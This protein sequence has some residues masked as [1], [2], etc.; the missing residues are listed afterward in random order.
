MK[1]PRRRARCGAK[2]GRFAVGAFLSCFMGT[3]LE[4][5][6]RFPKRNAKEVSTRPGHPST[7]TQW[8]QESCLVLPRIEHLKARF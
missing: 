5:G 3:P 7:Q 1:P 8:E 6:G 2:R 4:T